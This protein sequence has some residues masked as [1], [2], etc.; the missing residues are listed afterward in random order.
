MVSWT[1]EIGRVRTEVSSFLPVQ[2]T[3]M[4]DFILFVYKSIFFRCDGFIVLL[5]VTLYGEQLKVKCDTIK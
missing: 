1:A 2:I 4:A 5:Y 3:K